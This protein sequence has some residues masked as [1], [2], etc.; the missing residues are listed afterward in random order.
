[1]VKKE[2]N[3]EIFSIN[4]LNKENIIK[5]INSLIPRIENFLKANKKMMKYFQ[6]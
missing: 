3:D 6:I 4:N 1:M 5:K 2:K